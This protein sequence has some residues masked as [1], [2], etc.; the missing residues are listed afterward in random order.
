MYHLKL[1]LPCCKTRKKYTSPLSI[2]VPTRLVSERKES[3]NDK[4]EIRMEGEEEKSVHPALK[5]SFNI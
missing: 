5:I 1:L 4:T 2:S 3:K